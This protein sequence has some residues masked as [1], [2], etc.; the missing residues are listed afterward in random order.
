MTQRKGK[1]MASKT[2]VLLGK[3]S[4]PPVEKELKPHGCCHRAQGQPHTSSTAT[5]SG[6]REIF[7]GAF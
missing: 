4:S 7:Y 3:A 6:Q 2:Q 1:Q 5:H